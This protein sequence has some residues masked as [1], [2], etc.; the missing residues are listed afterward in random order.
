MK[1]F[2]QLYQSLDST[3]STQRKIEAIVDYLRQTPAEDAAWAIYFLG[4]GKLRRLV[5]TTSLREL[6]IRRSALAPWLFEECYQSVGD[7]AE[8]IALLWPEQASDRDD[9]LARCID[10]YLLNAVP[11]ARARSEKGSAGPG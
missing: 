2:A 11:S 4:A 7:L 1:R 5:S 8:T 3:T 10:T 6:A 9:S